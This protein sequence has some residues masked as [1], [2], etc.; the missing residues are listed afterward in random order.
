MS[1]AAIFENFVEESPVT[2][3][4]RGTL[5]RILSP[6][7]LNELF[8]K[9]AQ[10]QYTR[11][12]LFSDVVEVMMPVVAGMRPSVHASYQA[13][14]E[15]LGVSHASVYNKIDGVDSRPQYVCSCLLIGDK[16]LRI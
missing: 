7:K 8:D 1:L 15:K 9:T 10:Q 12:L 13:R 16:L 3:M 6:E 5:E 11:E 4:M 14:K 2:V